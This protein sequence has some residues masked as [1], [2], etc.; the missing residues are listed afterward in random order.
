MVPQ[1]DHDQH[2]DRDQ[3]QPGDD[4]GQPLERR[5]VPDQRQRERRV[6]HLPVRGD[7]REEQEAEA[8]EHE[9]V[10]GADQRPLEHPRVPERLAEHR[11]GARGRAV[12]AAD[13]RL[14]DPDRLDHRATVRTARPDRD[15]VSATATTIAS[16]CMR[17]PYDR[18][19]AAALDAGGVRPTARTGSRHG[20]VRREPARRSARARTARG[21]DVGR[22]ASANVT[23]ARGVGPRSTQVAVSRRRSTASHA[24][25]E[26][27]RARSSGSSSSAAIGGR[28]SRRSRSPSASRSAH[29]SCGLLRLA[30]ATIVT[31]TA[32]RSGR[33][34]TRTGRPGRSRHGGGSSRDGGE[35]ERDEADAVHGPPVASS[36]WT[37]RTPKMLGP[38]VGHAGRTARQVTGDSASAAPLGSRSA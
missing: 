17:R 25:A 35:R 34:W 8:D 33:P 36:V 1:P 2:R 24:L 30:T 32:P 16:A 9:P 6:E 7:E 13:R 31:I 27:D 3:H 23:D 21:T 37:G 28:R 15:T 4:L 19:R 18:A 20:R 5:P 11:R 12:G 10:R 26:H 29:S 22:R 38:R 14:A